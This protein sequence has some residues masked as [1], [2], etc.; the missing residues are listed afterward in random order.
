MRLNI[1]ILFVILNL[2]LN[3]ANAQV[4]IIF[5]TDM[6]GD[7]D[8]L[9]ALVMLHNLVD[10]N[11]C[12]LL[13]V[14]TWA[15]EKYAVKAID[16]V[17][18]FYGHPEIPVG[19][20]KDELWHDDWNYNKPIAE[21]FPHELSYENVPDATLLYRQILAG[22]PDTSITVVTVGPLLN[23]QRL[24]ASKPDTIS[25]L[26]GND[27]ISQ[28][29]KKFVIMGGHFPRG[30]GEW[31]FNGYMPG[32]THFVLSN[33]TV[34]V[35]FSG[36]EVGEKIKTGEVFN[37][38]DKNT[39]LYVGFSHFCKYAPWMQPYQGKIIDNSSFDQTAV[40]YAVR[41]G[42]GEYW[43]LVQNGYCEADSSGNNRW[44]EGKAQNH[45]YL[46]LKEDPEKM[47]SLIESIMLNDF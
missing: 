45:S 39:P 30:E 9:G 27:L 46:V 17:N 32:V 24:I 3:V 42:N 10:R 4:R 13:A 47:A 8:D 43:N 28:K 40:L 6:G 44:I 37:N 20:R 41:G 26:Q 33:L 7:A 12:D 2:A 25:P 14:M 23:I 18:R 31:N 5:D 16:A 35:I 19:T 34:P 11:E 22:H 15:N 21:A 38:I 1:I 36:F 29:V